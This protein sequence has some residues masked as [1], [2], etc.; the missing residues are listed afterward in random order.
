MFSVGVVF[1]SSIFIFILSGEGGGEE[2]AA[3]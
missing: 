2:G 1:R 3:R